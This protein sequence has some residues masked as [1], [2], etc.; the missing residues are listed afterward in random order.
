MGRPGWIA[1]R[2]SRSPI[3]DARKRPEAFDAVYGT[4]WDVMLR[5]M[6]RRTFDAEVAFDLAAETFT[7]MLAHIREFRGETE[8]AGQAWMWTIARSELAKWYKSGDV[9]R[10]Y[11][12]RFNVDPR[13]PGTDE[14][15]RIEELADVEPLRRTVQRALATLE[16][17][18]RLVLELRVV[19]EW[20][21]DEV[22]AALGI[23]VNAAQIRVARALALLAKAVAQLAN[24]DD[25]YRAE[26]ISEGLLT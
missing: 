19:Q 26:A 17:G 4:Y 23:S 5:F 9:A 1:A 21:Y 18:P 13:S 8:A 20:S 15:E 12:D 2:R 24:D 7:K 25:D 3:V 10:R 16:P 22:A 11:R 6:V 14:L